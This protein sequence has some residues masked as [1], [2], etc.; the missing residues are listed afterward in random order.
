[1]HIDSTAPVIIMLVD[2][3]II[4]HESPLF[5]LTNNSQFTRSN[6]QSSTSADDT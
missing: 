2:T 3:Q 5:P 1:M 6:T 4:T